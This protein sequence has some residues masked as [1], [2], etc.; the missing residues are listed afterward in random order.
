MRELI[1]PGVP[2]GSKARVSERER[3]LAVRLEKAL[4]D[5]IGLSLA[6]Q[7]IFDRNQQIA[8]VEVLARWDDA[9]EGPIS[10]SEFI[11]LAEKTGLIV[12][13]CKWVIR[14]AC[15]QTKRWLDQGFLLG[16]LAVNFS[17]VHIWREDFVETIFEALRESG[18]PAQMLELEVTESALVLDFE[19]VKQH[20]QMLRRH[21][22][23]ISI[24]DFGTGYS[25]LGRLRELDADVLKIDKIFVQGADEEIRGAAMVQAIVN[26]AHSLGLTVVAEG[27]ETVEQRNLVYQM[28]CEEIQ[29]YLLAHPMTPEELFILMSKHRNEAHSAGPPLVDTAIFSLSPRALET[30]EAQPLAAPLV[31][32]GIA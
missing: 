2:S 20:L 7:P 22:V 1:G 21:G 31:F 32:F 14:E 26:I 18:L 12:P 23:R 3:R 17:V 13:L 6:Y 10:P 29:G 30:Q 9:I 15:L 25:S 16:R 4:L 28:G 24:D 11:P 19:K 27:V 5:S 8:A